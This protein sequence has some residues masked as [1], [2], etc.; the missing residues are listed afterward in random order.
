M[1][2]PPAGKERRHP[3]RIYVSPFAYRFPAASGI[4]FGVTSNISESGLC[5]YSDVR[6][7]QGEQ[8]EFR[9]SLPVPS[10]RATVRWVKKD[11]ENLYKMGLVF[12]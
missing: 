5:V 7:D 8:I 9:S 11:A 2:S 1:T 6:P 12:E 3:R 10:S 4:H